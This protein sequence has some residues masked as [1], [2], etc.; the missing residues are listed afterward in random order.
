M[1]ENREKKAILYYADIQ[2]WH[3][4]TTHM[5]A[6]WL[7]LWLSNYHILHDYRYNIDKSFYSLEGFNASRSKKC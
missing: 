5:S 7:G 2:Y 4:Y 3:V 6:G 1:V